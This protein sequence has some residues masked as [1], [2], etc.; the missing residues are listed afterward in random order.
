VFLGRELTGKRKR[1]AIK[2]LS[3]VTEKEKCNNLREVCSITWQAAV[4]SSRPPTHTHS[5]SLVATCWRQI[6][7]LRQLRQA[8]IVRYSRAF[9]VDQELW[10]RWQLELARSFARS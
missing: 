8:N 1:V 7:F 4:P 6:D 9:I 2:K 10:V 3:H 5:L